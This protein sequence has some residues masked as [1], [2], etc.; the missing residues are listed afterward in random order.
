MLQVFP[1]GI[2][3]VVFRNPF[4][5]VESAKKITRN[6]SFELYQKYHQHLS[7]LDTKIIE[8]DVFYFSYDNLIEDPK[9][10]V[11]Q[12]YNFLNAHFQLGDN[13]QKAIDK[14]DMSLFRNRPKKNINDLPNNIKILYTSMLDK[15]I[16]V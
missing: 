13:R 7:V 4:S 3:L 5:V 8:N 6:S 11:D 2:L 1:K 16:K 15:T 10:S 14:I 12:L 9:T